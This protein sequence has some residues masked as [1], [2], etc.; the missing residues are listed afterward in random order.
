MEV[1]YNEWIDVKKEL[2]EPGRLHWV[3]DNKYN[4]S[5]AFWN[6]EEMCWSYKYMTNIFK[7]THFM[8]IKLPL[9][10]GTKP[11]NPTPDHGG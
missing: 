10:P 8:R 6:M 2:P 3:A 11:I 5:L 1:K 4:C 7:P 9:V